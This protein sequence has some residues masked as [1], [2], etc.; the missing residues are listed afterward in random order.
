MEA[1]RLRCL[2]WSSFSG[3]AAPYASSRCK[4]R[5]A[6]SLKDATQN[7]QRNLVFGP[8]PR[9]WK[10]YVASKKSS[11]S[12]PQIHPTAGIL[13]TCLRYI[14]T[15]HIHNLEYQNIHNIIHLRTFQQGPSYLVA[16]VRSETC[17]NPQGILHQSRRK[18]SHLR[19]DQGAS[20]FR[21]QAKCC[22][23]AR[24]EE[25]V[26][27]GSRPCLPVLV[28][29]Q[30][31]LQRAPRSNLVQIPSPRHSSPTT[32]AD[33]A[34]ARFCLQAIDW[35]RAPRVLIDPSGRNR[36]SSWSTIEIRRKAALERLTVQAPSHHHPNHE[37]DLHRLWR[38]PPSSR[39]GSVSSRRTC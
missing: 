33:E 37:Y 20:G 8:P 23:H 28:P 1:P 16:Q 34:P 21:R 6:G 26:A 22:A 36:S 31:H 30:E 39:K 29:R 17:A 9:A 14:Q 18:Q 25:A 15:Y 2:P 13:R 32:T 12:L 4:R 35:R 7:G 27:L 10:I 11:L 38:G 5:G 3:N 24:S 19:T